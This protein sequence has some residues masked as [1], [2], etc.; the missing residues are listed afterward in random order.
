MKKQI[1]DLLLKM[2]TG[3]N[4]IGE[5]ANALLIL[6]KVRRSATESAN[7]ISA[8]SNTLL[9]NK[10]VGTYKGLEINC[11]EKLDVL[12]KEIEEYKA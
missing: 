3:D 11:I 10:E 2:Q 5:T 12:V 1:N 9:A 4:C 6:F 8:L 7:L